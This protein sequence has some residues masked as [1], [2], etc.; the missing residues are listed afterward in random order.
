MKEREQRINKRIINIGDAR[1][2]I[3]D[4]NKGDPS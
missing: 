1:I 2:V 4:P 3:L